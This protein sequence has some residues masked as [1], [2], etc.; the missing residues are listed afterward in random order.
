MGGAYEL[1]LLQEDANET[2][3]VSTQVMQEL[4]AV[5]TRKFKRTISPEEADQALRRLVAMNVVV[6]VPEMIL[7]AAVRSRQDTLNFWDAL[8]VEAA[9]A[10]GAV[11]EESRL[12]GSRITKET[13]F[14]D[15]LDLR[16][17]AKLVGATE[18][19]EVREVQLALDAL[20]HEVVVFA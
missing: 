19:E 11:V 3:V 1:L 12:V 4:Y 10:G 2:L 5:V 17:V 13:V 15:V 6:V 14:A 9:L 16:A 20:L 8:I 7:A 18:I